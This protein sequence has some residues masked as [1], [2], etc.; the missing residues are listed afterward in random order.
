MTATITLLYKHKAV[1]SEGKF[2][3]DYYKKTHMPLVT[4]VWGP[5]GLNS[6]EISEIKDEKSP[7]HYQA[8][9]HWESLEAWLKAAEEEQSP[10][11][12]IPNY[13]NMELDRFDTVVTDSWSK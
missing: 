9:L 8:L 10:F 12:D 4:K 6:W 3:A 5:L 13:T 11:A 1:R 7:Y 2:D